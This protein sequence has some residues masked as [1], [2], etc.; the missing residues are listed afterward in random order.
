[1]WSAMPESRN[2]RH[3]RTAWLALTRRTLVSTL[4]LVLV[5]VWAPQGW[6]APIP[7]PE[8]IPGPIAPSTD[9]KRNGSS[10]SVVVEAT[11]PSSGGS[12]SSGT[13]SAGTS[14]SAGSGGSAG[15]AASAGGSAD[16]STVTVRLD[17]KEGVVVCDTTLPL[18]MCAMS[19]QIDPVTP[20]PTAPAAPAPAP[21]PVDPA[22]LARSIVVRLDVEAVT[23]GLAPPAGGN[24][25][26]IVGIPT[27]MWATSPT[28]NQWGTITAADQGI[29]LT[30]RVERVLWDMGD[31]TPPVICG[32]GTPWSTQAG[33][34]PNGIR[35]SPTCGHTYTRQG[36]YTIRATSDWA[37]TWSGYNQTGTIRLQ[38]HR[39]QAY[40][41]GEIHV[42][43]VPRR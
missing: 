16:M 24:S 40:P 30:G 43:N 34:S 27:W 39:L 26:G 3:S 10:G 9:L 5:G 17:P 37:F 28:P 22:T 38:V 14:W 4:A 19:G 13:G 6:A 32:Q 11:T 25:L 41:V 21:A 15:S 8:P 29:T 7:V 42:I 12:G 33:T 1:M 31:G 20:P 2:G 18:G 23:I 35:P 36:R